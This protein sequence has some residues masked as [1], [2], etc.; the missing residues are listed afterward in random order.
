MIQRVIATEAAL[1]LVR[2]LQ[3]EHGTLLFYQ[4]HG[5][6]DGSTPMLFVQGEM[7]LG[8][9]DVQLGEVAGVPFHASRMQLDYLAGSQL[10]LDVAPGSLGTFSLEDADGVHF[11]TRS[12][13]WTDEEWLVLKAQD[14]QKAQDDK[15]RA[16]ARS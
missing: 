6:C 15:A 13:L 3:Q 7:G 14:A 10:T 12:R 9:D 5:C 1:A 4:S 16:G 8:A 2:R 11:V